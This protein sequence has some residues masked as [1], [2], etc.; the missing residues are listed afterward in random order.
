MA[1]EIWVEELKTENPLL[2]NTITNIQTNLGGSTLGYGGGGS[3]GARAGENDLW[4]DEE[5]DDSRWDQL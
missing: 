1:P 5:D 3:G 4:D 2:G